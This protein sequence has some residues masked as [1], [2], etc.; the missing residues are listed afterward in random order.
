M[1]Q[2]FFLALG[3]F[4]SS[5]SLSPGAPGAPRLVTIALLSQQL[6]GHQRR[7]VQGTEEE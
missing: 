5:V 1:S 2:S 3:V 6:Q 7:K 4:A